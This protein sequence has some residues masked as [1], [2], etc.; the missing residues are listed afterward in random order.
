M[1]KTTVASIEDDDVWTYKIALTVYNI[2]SYSNPLTGIQIEYI[3]CNT[4]KI[5]QSSVLGRV[6]LRCVIGRDLSSAKT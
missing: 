2:A 4:H 5:A 6:A 1:F 3:A